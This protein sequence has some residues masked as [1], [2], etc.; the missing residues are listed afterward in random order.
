MEVKSVHSAIDS[1]ISGFK[2]K[3]S[4]RDLNDEILVEFISAFKGSALLNAR[5]VKGL[6]VESIVTFVDEAENK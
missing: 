6:A 3:L 4:E 1:F 5:L 2:E